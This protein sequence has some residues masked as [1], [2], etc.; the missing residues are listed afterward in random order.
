VS[1]FDPYAVAAAVLAGG[2]V[3][4]AVPAVRRLAPDL[5]EPSLEGGHPHWWAGRPDAG[6]SPAV[7]VAVGLVFVMVTASVL[8]GR[9]PGPVMSIVAVVA[10]SAVA[11]G[12]GWLPPAAAHRRRWQVLLQTPQVLDLLAAALDAGLPL[13]SATAAVVTACPG[14]VAD[15]LDGVLHQVAL[16][17]SDADAWR[18]LAH[19]PQLG[20]AAAD[21]ARSVESG[22]GMAEAL[23]VHADEARS[24]RRGA[25]E[26]QARR[27]GVRSVLPL[28]I[29]FLP[30]FLLLGIVPTVVSA[31]LQAVRL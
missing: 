1:G 20:D 21:L 11:I 18:G 6:L 16:G 14:P 19:H 3:G 12:L 10:G 15:E 9:L 23:A 22:T 5:G 25:I 31:V 17:V 13:R 26:L 30:A 29:C 7:R 2:A 28:M 24:Q 4:L 8:T 27:V